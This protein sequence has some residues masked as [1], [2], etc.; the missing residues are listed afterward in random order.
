MVGDAERQSGFAGAD[1]FC[2][3]L[4]VPGDDD[5]FALFD[6]FKEPGELGLGFVDVDLHTLR[7]VYLSSSPRRRVLDAPHRPCPPC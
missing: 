1:Q 5:T 6:Q 4:S 2:H 3:G 7:L